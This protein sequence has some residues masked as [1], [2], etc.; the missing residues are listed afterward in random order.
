[1]AGAV[2]LAVLPMVLLM[3]SAARHR[4]DHPGTPVTRSAGLLLASGVGLVMWCLLLFGPGTTYVHSG[5][6][7]PILLATCL[8]VAWWIDRRPAWAGALGGVQLA[9]LALLYVPHN[10]PGFP[11][12]FSRKATVTVVVALAV[13]AW[14]LWTARPTAAETEEERTGRPIAGRDSGRVLLRPGPLPPVPAGRAVGGER[15]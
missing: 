2:G 8:P 4:R 1:M 15:R 12:A 13:L 3:V 11:A 5:S 6:H 10:Y 9:L 7:V 14:A